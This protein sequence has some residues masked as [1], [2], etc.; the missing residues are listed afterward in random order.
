MGFDSLHDEDVAFIFEGSSPDQLTPKRYYR[1]T[2]D[3]YA[4]FGVFINIGDDVTGLLHRNELDQRLESLSWEPGDTVFVQV[5]NIR[6]NGNVD[7]SWSTRQS[8][9]EFRGTLVDTPEGDK[10]YTGPEETG[11]GPDEPDT[12][13][14]ADATTEPESSTPTEPT[15]DAEPATEESPTAEPATEESPTAEPIPETPPDVEQDALRDHVDDPVRVAGEVQEIRQTSGP[16]IFTLRDATGTI[17]AAAFDGAGVRAYPEVD[18]GDIVQIDGRV[19]KRRGELQI[20]TERLAILSGD[21][22]TAVAERIDAAVAEA[23][24]PDS[25][26]YLVDDDPVAPLADDLLGAATTLRRAVAASRPVVIRHP[27]TVDGYAAGAALE[28]ALLPRITAE[29]DRGDAEYHYLDRRPVDDTVYGMDGAVGD[30]ANALEITRRH[31]E[32]LPLVVLLGFG[33]SGAAAD[34]IEMLGLYD[35]ETVVVDPSTPAPG[36]TGGADSVVTPH[37]GDISQQLTATA[38]VGSLATTITP[39]AADDLRYLPATSYWESPPEPYVQAA[40]RAGFTATTRR[41]VREALAVEAYYQ[42]H[43]GK[44]ALI[45]DL[46]FGDT[47]SF[48]E[49]V[50]DQYR[51]RLDAELDPARANLTRKESGGVRFVVLDVDQ[52]AN[53]FDFPPTTLL[54]N[55]LHREE[56]AETT[57]ELVTMGIGTDEIH[58]RST[59]PVDTE[60]VVDRATEVVDGIRAVGGPDGYIEFLPGVREEAVEAVVGAV[61]ARVNH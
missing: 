39:A 6:D 35:I 40:E 41:R 54:L 2:V 9:A 7:L 4:D 47:G 17:E 38:L 45:R 3:G 21:D 42:S 49:H 1:G 24:A 31:D 33:S 34:A 50:A 60:A 27:A 56:R 23:A 57:A 55:E 18:V 16:T 43:D 28:R 59:T 13:P 20:E 5:D 48:V 52:F 61:A 10:P 25:V 11:T 8:L 53:R 36:A 14:Q 32:R 58:I 19:E 26:T 37:K 12:E 46:L 15:P 30:L 29:H 51:E 44:R 22:A